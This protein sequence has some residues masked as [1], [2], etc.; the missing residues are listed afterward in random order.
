MNPNERQKY[1]TFCEET[2]RA[3]GDILM[4]YVGK[5]HVYEKGR[6]DL[7]TE[8][9]FASQTFVKER[10]LQYFPDHLILGEENIADT[11]ALGGPGKFR[12]IVDPLDGT[13]NYVHGMPF[14]CVSLALEADGELLVGAIYA[15]ALGE[16]YTAACGG[17]AFLNGKPIHV[18]ST[19]RLEDSLAGFGF[20]ADVQLESPDLQTFLSLLNVCHA[21]RR[22]GS[23]A[24]NLAYVA[25]GRFDVV[26]NFRTHPWDIAAG[27]LLVREA[28]GIVVDTK[29]A[30]LVLDKGDFIAAA[31]EELKNQLTPFFP[32]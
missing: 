16:C 28:G 29:N 30:S 4:D 7:V 6:S 24:L 13:T 2:A 21:L 26:W 17:G 14:F 5:F 20:P 19:S 31:S 23:A 27:V 22:M 9:D 15:P 10:I 8:A 12:W 11:N 1:Q 32:H 3:A 25:A 18:S